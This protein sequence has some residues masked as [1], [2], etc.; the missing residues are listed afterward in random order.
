MPK[1]KLG[2]AKLPGEEEKSQKSSYAHF[3]EENGHKG[4]LK[5]WCS[6]EVPVSKFSFEIPG[7]GQSGE[8]CGAKVATHFDGDKK[9]L[10]EGRLTCKRPSCPECWR[11]WSRRRTF[12]M[13]VAI[14]LEAYIRDER[15]FFFLFSVP[16]TE[17]SGSWDWNRVNTSLFRRGYRRGRKHRIQGGV[18]VFHAHRIKKKYQAKFQE[19]GIGS[20]E[21]DV[22]YW[23]DGVR[24]DVLDLGN[25]KEYV[26]FG[27]HS[28]GVGFGEP[29][30]HKSELFYCR[31]C[32]NRTDEIDEAGGECPKCGSCNT[33]PTFILRVNDK[34]GSPK[35]QDLEGVVAY[36]RYLLS[37]V[38]VLQNKDTFNNP[39]RRWGCVGRERKFKVQGGIKLLEEG[40]EV[41]K[42]KLKEIKKEVA[43]LVGMEWS[44]EGGLFYPGEEE[45][46]EYN[47]R[48][49]YEVQFM[50]KRTP[51]YS[52]R[53][54]EFL[55]DLEVI[56]SN[57]GM[58]GLEI[59]KIKELMPS[60]WVVVKL[61]EGGP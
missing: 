30:G 10:K 42:K 4:G 17:V 23:I 22:G 39:T 61:A 45:D 14:E 19:M 50:K 52:M 11:D 5:S 20:G 37:H 36:C 48:P 55:E 53:D 9:A 2:P 21:R 51:P 34:N 44:E 8:N 58:E 27:P 16:P 38:G 28:H 57:Q 59:D 7:L 3:P 15:P 25:W 46:Q 33:V 18:N 24:E 1:T 43:Q 35:R 40:I 47:W 60:T 6:V 29:K 54:I 12:Q 49:I 26:N 31:D 32:E 13:A 41:R 56:L